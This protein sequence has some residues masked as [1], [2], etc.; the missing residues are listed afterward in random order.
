[1]K[2][3]Q[4][5][6]NRY[7]T[8]SILSLWLA[9]TL[10]SDLSAQSSSL[11]PQERGLRR[12]LQ[13]YV[14]GRDS[15]H[16]KTRIAVAFVDLNGDRQQEALVY[17]MGRQRCGTGGCS[18]WILRRV[19]RGWRMVGQTATVNAPIRVLDSRSH[20]WRDIGLI[21]RFNAYRRY[22]AIWSYSGGRYP[23]GEEAELRG[24]RAGQRKAL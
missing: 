12:S 22:E 7:I 9:A 16:E 15:R 20:G 8:G 24:R 3:L 1:M 6:P 17:V 10:S 19:R 2:P 21:E 14:D 11:T 23:Y 4:I 5:T 13:N 18:L